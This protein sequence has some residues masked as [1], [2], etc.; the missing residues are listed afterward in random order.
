MIILAPLP[1]EFTEMAS[2]LLDLADSVNDVQTTTVTPNL[3]LV[4]PDYLYERYQQYL[5]LDTESDPSLPVRKKRR[6]KP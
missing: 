4:I 1:E 6:S 3:G 5:E 2:V